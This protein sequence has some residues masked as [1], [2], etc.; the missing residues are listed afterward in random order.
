VPDVWPVPIVFM[1]CGMAAPAGQRQAAE[2]W[3]DHQ[4]TAW[5][6]LTTIWDVVI[7]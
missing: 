1:I 6:A 7:A 3:E 4:A 5:T 2:S